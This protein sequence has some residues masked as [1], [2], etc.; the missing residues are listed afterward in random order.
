MMMMMMMMMMM[1]TSCS[2][3]ILVDGYMYLV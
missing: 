1:D 2:S 3:G